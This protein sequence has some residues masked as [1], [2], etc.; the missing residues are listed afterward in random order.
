MASKFKSAQFRI[1]KI[2]DLPF[3]ASSATLDPRLRAAPRLS[4]SGS[5]QSLDQTAME[6]PIRPALDRAVRVPGEIS[7]LALAAALV[8][9]VQD[10]LPALLRES[11]TR[12]ATVTVPTLIAG[13]LSGQIN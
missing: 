3:G 7:F 10:N 4:D 1:L 6:G 11:V 13:A 2:L 8:A 9:P 12:V 5:N